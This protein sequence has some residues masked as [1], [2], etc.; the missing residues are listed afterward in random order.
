MFVP[1]YS[2]LERKKLLPEKFFEVKINYDK[3]L[4]NL[5]W[6]TSAGL[7]LKSMEDDGRNRPREQHFW[8][9]MSKLFDV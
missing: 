7:P 8:L 3:V 1:S 4:T 5:V 6:L 9:I 2:L